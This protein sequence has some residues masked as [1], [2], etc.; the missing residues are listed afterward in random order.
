MKH[1]VDTDLIV[2]QLRVR[3]HEV[4]HVIPVSD[5]AGEFEFQVDG[6]LLS[7]AEVRALLEAEP[8]TTRA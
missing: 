8:Q 2:E 1:F 4:G 6:G 3:G 5:N 7:L